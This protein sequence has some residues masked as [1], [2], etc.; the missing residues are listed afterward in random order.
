MQTPENCGPGGLLPGPKKRTNVAAPMGSHKKSQRVFG[1]HIKLQGAVDQQGALGCN[2]LG[3]LILPGSH[4]KKWSCYVHRFPSHSFLLQVMFCPFSLL[5]S[6]LVPPLRFL[7]AQ[8]HQ[9]SFIMYCFASNLRLFACL[10]VC[11]RKTSDPL[12]F[13]SVLTFFWEISFN[14]QY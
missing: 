2:M 3:E 10:L 14:P 9:L 1:S 12:K 4:Q 11:F 7:A 5:F 6:C 13:I 8:L